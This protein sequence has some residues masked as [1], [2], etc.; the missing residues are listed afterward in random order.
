MN[1]R[2][3]FRGVGSEEHGIRRF[4]FEFDVPGT[5][6][7]LET[8]T[9]TRNSFTRSCLILSYDRCRCRSECAVNCGVEYPIPTAPVR[10]RVGAVL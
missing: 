2:I 7:C 1:W 5:L 8:E 9:R 4:E 10:T 6:L 3:A